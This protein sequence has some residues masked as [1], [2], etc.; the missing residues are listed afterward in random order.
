MLSVHSKFVGIALSIAVVIGLTVAGWAQGTNQYNTGGNYSIGA[1]PGTNCMK[2]VAQTN[3]QNPSGDD[4]LVWSKDGKYLATDRSDPT[5]SNGPN[6]FINLTGS[7]KV[8]NFTN[9]GPRCTAIPASNQ[10]VYADITDFTCNGDRVVYVNQ[11]TNPP[12]RQRLMSCSV[13]G[14]LN[15]TMFLA[16]NS[17][18]ISSPSIIYD[19]V[20]Q[21]ERL[22]FLA[23]PTGGPPQNAIYNLYTIPF[24]SGGVPQ[25]TNRQALT[26]F[27]TNEWIASAKWC[28]EL[29]TNLQPLVNRYALTK[30]YQ[31]PPNQPS[32]RGYLA[33]TGLRAILSGNTN[34]GPTN[35]PISLADSRFDAR[36]T[37]ASGGSQ[38]TWTFDG[39]FL[40]C[41]INTNPA[42]T[43]EQMVIAGLFSIPSMG[44]NRAPIPFPTPPQVAPYNKKWPTISPNGMKAAFVVN[45]QV[46]MLPLQC[47]Q[48]GTTNAGTTNIITDGSYT[49]VEIPGSALSTNSGVTNFT[50]TVTEPT[51]ID[52][53]RFSSTF[54]GNTRQF[55]VSGVSS[56]FD[57]T[58]NVTMSL[59]YD[60]SDVPTNMSATNMSIFL[61]NP[62]SNAFGKTGTWSQCQSTV[63]TNTHYVTSSNIQHFS[64]YALGDGAGPAPAAPTNLAASQGTYTN[65]VLLTWDVVTNADGYY[66]YRGTNSATNSA[67]YI[68]VS[69]TNTYDDL[70]AGHATNYYYWV[71]ASNANGASALSASNNGYRGLSAPTSLTASDGTY[72]DKVAVT[73]SAVDGAFSYIVFRG[74]NAVT[75]SAVAIAWP[76]A[77]NYDDTNAVAGT[78]YYYW[79]KATNPVTVSDFSPSNSG[80]RAVPPDAPASLTASAGTYTDKVAV[81]WA[82]SAWASGYIVLR[83]TNS[84]TNSASPIGGSVSTNYDDTTAGFGTNY[85]YWAIATNAAGI[86]GL[87]P[88][89]SGFRAL[90]APAALNATDGAYT[91]KVAVVWAASPGASGYLLLRGT[92]ASTNSASPIATPA[93]TNFDDTS[94]VPVQVY[95]YWSVATNALGISALSPSNSGYRAAPLAPPDAPASLAASDGTY[96]DKVAVTWSASATASGYLV[97]RSP[98]A[99]TNTA[100]PIGTSATTNFNDTN[101]APNVTNYYWVA[102]TNAAGIS[103]LSPS[104]SGYRASPPMPPDA[105][106]SLTA[107]DGTYTDKVAVSW[108]ASVGAL[109]YIVIRGPTASTSSAAPIGI[110]LTTNYDDLTAVPDTTY[111]Y[112]AAATNAAGVSGPSPSNTGYR[113][114]PPTPP[115]LPAPTG[116]AASDG[117][118]SDKVRVTWNSVTGAT[119][120]LVYRS[121]TNSS[122]SATQAGTATETTYDDTA[123]TNWP[124]TA[125]YY[126]VKAA[127]SQTTSVF[128]AVAQGSCAVNPALQTPLSGDF[129]G[130]SKNDLVLYQESSGAW[131]FKL[132]A[133]GYAAASAT[134]GGI[135]YQPIAKDFDGDGK[136]DP[137]V[138][139]TATGDWTIMLSGSSYGIVRLLAFGDA[140]YSPVVGDF[141]GDRKA[142][143][144]VYQDTD[145]IWLVKLSGSGYGTAVLSGFGGAGYLAVAVD[146]DGDGKADPA[147]YEIATGDWTVKLSG[148]GYGSASI[149]GFGGPGYELVP[150]MYDNDTRADAAIYETATGT[151]EVLLSASAY[152]TASLYGFGG[153]GCVPVAGDF[154][155]DGKVDPA[156]YEQATSTWYVKLSASGYTTVTA[157][158]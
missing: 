89:N 36:I 93:V 86:S 46:V 83:G 137:T 56:Q 132:S 109:G 62:Q 155:G 15:V 153:A 114:S 66:V 108:S 154:D 99:A 13:T 131:S 138:Y 84:A 146:F 1:P 45:G 76:V 152:I 44:T 67:G 87:S 8:G 50:F 141:D 128:S 22:L 41:G 119:S 88:S 157:P 21:K 97:L 106:A 156:Y 32:R 80:F 77:T 105:P 75:T 101:V 12:F 48:S 72:T 100:S 111:Y 70:T 122:S 78:Y 11:L 150:G 92:N 148:S 69:G 47:E 81:N 40:M 37:N 107:S 51:D 18:N 134:L 25:W 158:Q 49:K 126:W 63:D 142:D 24:A 61:Y 129:D 59:H 68:G 29:G 121:L 120:Y 10:T 19:P 135:G 14:N 39:K 5:V 65:K 96:T 94:A 104:N 74:S 34:F 118:Y 125:L 90:M 103:G 139:D 26:A 35:L 133:S 145:G 116:V 82:A 115:S 54:V 27:T 28:P 20:A 9:L 23:A 38:V 52:T 73:W 60:D 95:Y 31:I 85:Y 102:A 43:N 144:T 79:A 140:G 55:G 112:W 4:N 2:W 117:T 58:T 71:T 124:E 57:F 17:N 6:K 64:I 143:P 130:D 91:D 53:N 151:W 3:A 42:A 98:S 30:A 147:T 33:F 16:D 110:S 113:A 149:A 7:D 136:A 127:N 123:A